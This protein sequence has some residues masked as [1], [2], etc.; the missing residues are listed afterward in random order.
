[1]EYAH[2]Q[3]CSPAVVCQPRSFENEIPEMNKLSIS[4]LQI[5]YAWF[6]SKQQ[7]ISH[8]NLLCGWSS[9][10]KDSRAAVLQ[11]KVAHFVFF[12]VWN[13]LFFFTPLIYYVALLILHNNIRCTIQRI[14]TWAHLIIIIMHR[15]CTYFIILSEVE[16]PAHMCMYVCVLAVFAHTCG[17]SMVHNLNKTKGITIA[18]GITAQIIL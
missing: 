4:T 2:R 13:K 7:T 6:S 18:C 8:C 12:W 17:K 3:N 16:M 11:P 5:L 14:H 10:Q 15:M 9:L 1:M